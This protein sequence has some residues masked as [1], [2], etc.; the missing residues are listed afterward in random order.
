MLRGHKLPLVPVSYRIPAQELHQA[1]EQLAAEIARR[2]P[3]TPRLVLLGVANGGIELA[4][5]IGE[6]LKSF[7]VGIIDISFHRDDIGNQPIPKE[8]RSTVIPVDVSGATVILVD[9]VL[10]TGRTI[11]AALDELF[12]HGRP[13][14]VELATLI[15]RGGRLLPVAADYVGLT[16][17]VTNSEKVVVSLDTADPRKDHVEIV[18]AK[19]R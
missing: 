12:D 10:H 16:L 19:V 15:E 5:R 3:R 9:D 11:K 8:Y 7:P 6:R 18:P 14:K 17:D 2:H 4:R 13:A 1:I